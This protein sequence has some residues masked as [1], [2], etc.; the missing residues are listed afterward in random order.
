M[1]ATFMDANLCKHLFT[2]VR[3]FGGLDHLRFRKMFP[4]LENFAFFVVNNSLVSGTNLNFG[5]AA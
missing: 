1:T 3:L 5:L 4:F 2:G